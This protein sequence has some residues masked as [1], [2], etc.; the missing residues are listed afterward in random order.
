MGLFVGVGV[1][2]F[3]A[4]EFE[5]ILLSN[6]VSNKIRSLRIPKDIQARAKILIV[7]DEN[8]HKCQ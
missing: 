5:K 2:L 8:R 3:I 6:Q 4:N 7:A 1:F